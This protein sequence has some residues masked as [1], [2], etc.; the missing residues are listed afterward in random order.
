[1]DV[2]DIERQLG[3][4]AVGGSPTITCN[5]GSCEEE[6]LVSAFG[7]VIHPTYTASWLPISDPCPQ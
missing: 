3:T 2:G 5:A 1:M 6:S 4:G 7:Y